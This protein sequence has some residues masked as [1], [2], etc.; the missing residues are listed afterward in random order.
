MRAL[1]QPDGRTRIYGRAATR[2]FTCVDDG[3]RV[4][5]DAP[6]AAGQIVNVGTGQ[7]TPI[8]DL[9]RQI[10]LLFNLPENRMIF[11][12]PR[13]WD[14]AVRRCALGRTAACLIGSCLSARTA[15]TSRPTSGSATAPLSRHVHRWPDVD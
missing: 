11:E 8:V 2:D 12:E 7:D 9:A 10:L 5:L 6:H 15:T 13:A 1:D 3:V 4:L 14:R